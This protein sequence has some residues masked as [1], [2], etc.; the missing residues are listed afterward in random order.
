MKFTILTE[1]R[2]YNNDC[3]NEDGLS[4]LIEINND[5]VL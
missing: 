4:I 3:I 2:N 1:N 5:K